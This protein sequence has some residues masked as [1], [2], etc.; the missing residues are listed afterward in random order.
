M[1]I[2]ERATSQSFRLE[3]LNREFFNTLGEFAAFQR[4]GQPQSN[5]AWQ[6]RILPATRK[7]AEW[8]E[9]EMMWGQT[10]ETMRHLLKSLEELYK[11]AANC[12]RMETKKWKRRWAT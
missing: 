11:A 8:E 1:Q 7:L 2:V 5:Y 3:Q 6:S 12:I 10:S 4:E 9:V